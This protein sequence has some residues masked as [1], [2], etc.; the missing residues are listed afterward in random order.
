MRRRWPLWPSEPCA[1]AHSWDNGAARSHRACASRYISLRLLLQNRAVKKH[2]IFW[3]GCHTK[4]DEETDWNSTIRRFDGRTG[5]PKENPYACFKETILGL[6]GKGGGFF[7]SNSLLSRGTPL[8]QFH[9]GG[10]GCL[11]LVIAL[12]QLRGSGG[13]LGTR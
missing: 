11:P 10:W 1:D 7:S 2:N 3:S 4:K 5:L 6:G 13:P 9:L 8:S 12:D